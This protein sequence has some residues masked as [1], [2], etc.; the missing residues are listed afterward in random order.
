VILKFYNGIWRKGHLPPDWKESL[1]KPMLKLDKPAFD[2]A[3]Y[4]PVALTSTLCKLME[5]MVSTR[6]RWWLEDKQLFNKFQSGF[7]KNRST[8]DQI[9]RL[10]YDAHKAVHNK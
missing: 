4:R 10:T 2:V 1:I 6:L 3:S 7:K 5:K 8:I 9:L